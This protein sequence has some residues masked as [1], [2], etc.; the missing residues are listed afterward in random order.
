MAEQF[1]IDSDG[2]V[3]ESLGDL[4]AA[5]DPRWRRPLLF[6]TDSWDRSLG[7]KL[8]QAPQQPREWLAAMDEDG[9]DVMVLYPTSGLRIGSLHEADFATALTR[10]YNDWMRRFCDSDPER[11]KY[12]A[13]LAPQDAP[14]AAHELRRATTDQNAVGGVLPT[15]V[16]GGLDW[17]DALYDP[18][19]A[20]AERLD[21]PLGFH[22]GT[23]HDSVGALRFHK[24]MAAHTV[25]HPMEQMFALCGTILGGVFERFPRLRI[26]YLESGIGWVPYM[27]DRL[28]EEFEKRG[29]VEAPSLTKKPSEYVKSGRIFFGV[30]CEEKTVPDGVAWGLEDT[31]LYASDYPHWDGDWPHTTARV[32]RRK[33]LSDEV[34]RK[35]LHQNALHFYGPRLG[36]IPGRNQKADVGLASSGS[37]H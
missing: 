35:M 37:P 7:G 3:R 1:V 5:L 16:A 23:A 19:F 34:K 2:H 20:E 9:I 32:R 24:F 6:P 11:L 30:E 31:L 33:D 8:G 27:M 14:A 21:V 17:G 13:L 26:A 29:E 28:D 12:V 25:D 36:A 10:V 22:T 18:I 4:R 15:H